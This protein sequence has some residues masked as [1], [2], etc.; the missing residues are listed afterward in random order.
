MSSGSN[1]ARRVAS[2]LRPSI[3][4]SGVCRSCQETIGRRSYAT[5]TPAATESTT[6]PPV[7]TP[8]YTINAGVVLSR[9]P[10]ITRE[11]EPFEKA[12][13]FYQ[14]RLN[15]RLAL[16]FTKYFYFKRG[17]PADEDW[18]KKI[19][20]RRT[21]ARDIGKYNAYDSDAWNDEL[22]LGAE[23]SEPANQ[24]EALV[25]DAES[26]ANATSQDTSKKE[27]IPRPYSRITEAD[28]K[29]DQKSLNRLLSR[30]L[31]LLVQSKEGNWKFPTSPVET[32][33]TLRLAAERT[34]SDSAGVNMNT[35]MVGYHPVGWHQ[36]NAPRAKKGETAQVDASGNKVFFLKSR[37]MGGQADLSI[38]TQNLK[39]FKWLAKE[40]LP[41]YLNTQYYSNIKNMLA[42]R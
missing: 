13:F 30:T 29:N 26:T 34:L 33:E 11:L 31:Y 28:Q 21:A 9:P 15:E 14:K 24:I 8:A 42:D 16:P 39:D 1:S 12:F 7:V 40:E 20:E 3:I 10:Q 6:T 23:Q 18:K 27:D 41:Q 32:G 22:L 5:A 19:Q 17:T 25:Q 38:N 37:I 4:D 2:L 36:F 35:W